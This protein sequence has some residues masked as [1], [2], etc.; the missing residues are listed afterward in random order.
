M[1]PLGAF[2]SVSP[3]LH[4]PEPLISIT[5]GYCH[6]ANGN[7]LPRSALLAPCFNTLPLPVLP[8]YHFR[9]GC[10][11][12]ILKKTCR[13]TGAC[14][15]KGWRWSE[16]QSLHGWRRLWFE[17]W[18]S[19][20]KRVSLPVPVEIG[21]SW[22]VK[23]L[24]WW[25]CPLNASQQW[26][27]ASTMVAQASSPHSHPFRLSLQLSKGQL[28]GHQQLYFPWVCSPNPTS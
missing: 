25:P 4:S 7:H 17:E 8:D 12:L 27:I 28:K 15:A 18:V 1:L 2:L 21:A 19:L 22:W 24:R 20:L 26:H 23:G 9:L 13:S 6:I 16:P 10:P 11:G 5:L 14:M 3:S